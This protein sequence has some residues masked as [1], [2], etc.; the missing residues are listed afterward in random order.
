MYAHLVKS[1]S[2]NLKTLND[3]KVALSLRCLFSVNASQKLQKQQ[4]KDETVYAEDFVPIKRD[5]S[6][7][8]N[9]E[10][11]K[12]TDNNTPIAYREKFETRHIGVSAKAEAE[13][14]KT[15]NFKVCYVSKAAKLTNSFIK[16]FC[17]I[18]DFRRFDRENSTQ[19]N[20]FQQGLE[21][22]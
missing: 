8:Q 10:L 17:F 16:S 5:F 12:R 21:S 9:S 3:K 22:D 18:S 14:L 6:N 2:R 20:C 13:M 1:Q 11:H 19:A 4:V 7:G 15:L